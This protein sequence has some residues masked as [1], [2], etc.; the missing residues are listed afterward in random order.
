M[1][2][3]PPEKPEWGET[4]EPLVARPVMAADSPPVR[5]SPLRLSHRSRLTVF[6]EL[7]AVGGGMGV[8]LTGIVGATL[9][10]ALLGYKP[11]EK[12][13]NLVAA[14]A[15]GLGAVACVV[16][17]LKITKDSPAS[18]G[19]CR[20]SIGLNLLLGLPATAAC[21]AALII[22]VLLIFVVDEEAYRELSANAQQVR[23]ML[24]KLP[25]VGFL[26]LS[27]FV[28]VWE[29]LVFRGYLL[30]RLRRLTGS[31]VLAVFLS[32]A[33]F[34]VL[35]LPTQVWLFAFPLFLLSVLLSVITIWRRSIVPAIVGHALFD[36]TQLLA[37]FY[38][39]P[40]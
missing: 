26:A 40:E 36:Y 22:G 31:W 33:V 16:V 8:I 30:S 35:H 23:E 4:P 12:V 18:V 27:C 34:A 20:R 37:I 39:Q 32:S 38:L 5:P 25:M 6:W 13:I 17:A 9:L 14:V 24:P 1:P 2:E 7:A 19:L 3:I 21:Y 28:G 29:E 10:A 15:S 11:P